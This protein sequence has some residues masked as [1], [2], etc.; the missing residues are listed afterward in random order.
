MFKIHMDKVVFLYYTIIL[1]HRHICR[2]N[3]IHII[4]AELYHVGYVRYAMLLYLSCLQS[5][6][7]T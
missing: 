2:Y 4:Y 3:A 1:P 5:Y 7:L 6:H